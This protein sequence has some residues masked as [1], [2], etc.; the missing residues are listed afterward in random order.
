VRLG[1]YCMCECSTVCRRHEVQFLREQVRVGKGNS[2]VQAADWTW[3]GPPTDAHSGRSVRGKVDTKPPNGESTTLAA[4]VRLARSLGQSG[5][6]RGSIDA[7]RPHRSGDLP[8][9]LC[10]CPSYSACRI[11]Y[12]LLDGPVPGPFSKYARRLL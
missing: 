5:Q 12:V 6:D 11:L 1:T 8:A 3:P 9:P 10:V 4:V 7:L 2:A